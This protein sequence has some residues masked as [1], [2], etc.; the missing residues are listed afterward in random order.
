V[1]DGVPTQF[2]MT[3]ELYLC[4]LFEADVIALLR[5]DYSFQDSNFYSAARAVAG[6]MNTRTGWSH[7]PG[8]NMVGWVKR[9]RNSPVVYLQGGDD[10][11]AMSNPH[12]RKLVY[13]AI[14]WVSS[15]EAHSWVR[16][17]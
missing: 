1:T 4:P 14:R 9:Y 6:A 8:P 7:P 10:T 17:D 2:D 12:F 3:D 13:N 11:A 16:A 5:S 15:E